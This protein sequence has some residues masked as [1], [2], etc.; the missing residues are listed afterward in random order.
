MNYSK[1]RYG[2]VLI[3]LA[4]FL[5]L[6]KFNFLANTVEAGTVKSFQKISDTEGGFTGILDDTDTFGF[7]SNIGDLD[8]DNVAD[9]AVGANW[10][11]VK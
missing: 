9:I 3:I 7:V 5:F 1:I 10:R 6:F 11:D 2:P 4:I 8:G